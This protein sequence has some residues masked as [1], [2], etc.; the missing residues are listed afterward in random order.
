MNQQLNILMIS[1]HRRY[2]ITTRQHPIAKSLVERGHRV[3]IL[4]T[5][6]TRRKGIKESEWDG[7]KVVEAPDLL[8]GRLRSGWDP[9]SVFWRTI[10]LSQDNNAYDIVHCFETRPATIHPALYFCKRLHLPLLTDWI[11]WIGRGGLI[12]VNRPVWY[13]YLFGQVETYYEES[14]RAGADG[15][16]V[17]SNA[18]ANRAIDLGIP[19]EKIFYLP[20]GTFPDLFQMRSTDECRQ[21]VNLNVADGPVI[22]F[23]SSD[24]HLDLEIVMAALAIVAQQFPGI[25][26]LITGQTGPSIHELAKE[27]EVEEYLI[28]TGFLPFEDL[29]WYLGCADL[30]VL[31][32]PDTI[33]NRGRWPNKICDYLSLGR[34]T[35]ANPTGDIKFLFEKYEI[36]LLAEW[37]PEDF[38][39]K[40]ITLLKDSHLANRLGDEA[41]KVACEYR[42]PIL[43]ERLEDFYFETLARKSDK[44]N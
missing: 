10:Y 31:P 9:W 17:I 15:L 23:S 28:L 29:P 18:L 36:G 12:T 33:Y 30:F 2:R 25:K 32:F 39:Q 6:D 38:A 35:V 44:L 41:R 11:D 43:V 26:L 5:A 40:I 13:R 27:Y 3:T 42:W 34:P 20:G 16:T 7:F 21:R 22:G 24:T 8:W 19:P 1:H 14:F 4:V 37:D